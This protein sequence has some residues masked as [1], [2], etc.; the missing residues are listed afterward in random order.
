MGSGGRGGEEA[1]EG[2]RGARRPR[3]L[4]VPPRPDHDKGRLWRRR[5]GGEEEAAAGRRRRDGRTRVPAD[6]D[7]VAAAAERHAVRRGG[8]RRDPGADGRRRGVRRGRRGGGGWAGGV[9]APR[10]RHAA[11]GRVREVQRRRRPAGRVTPLRVAAA[12]RVVRCCCLRPVA[13]V[14]GFI[15]LSNGLSCSPVTWIYITVS[16]ELLFCGTLQNQN[17]STAQKSVRFTR[18]KL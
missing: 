16:S 7:H 18:C 9:L 5:R 1:G 2:L 17:R 8:H 13:L 12:C 4:Q 15:F 10:R 3:L 11:R 14:I 6:G